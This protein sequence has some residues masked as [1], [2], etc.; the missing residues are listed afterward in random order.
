[1]TGD[2]VKIVSDAIPGIITADGLSI[3]TVSAI[4]LDQSNN[5]VVTATN[6][7]TFSI[8][9]DGTWV[10]GSTSTVNCVPVNGVA[11]VRA[12]STKKS[13]SFSVDINEQ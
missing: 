12:K 7:I 6:T 9:G 11:T 5:V 13:G 8:T 10:D 4:I 2:P 3:S 1:V